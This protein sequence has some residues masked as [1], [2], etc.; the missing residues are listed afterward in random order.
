MSFTKSGVYTALKCVIDS[1]IPSNAGFYRPIT[2]TA[3]EGRSS[4]RAAPPRAPRAADWLQTRRHRA[5]RLAGAIPGR[6]PAAGD[7]GATMI[8]IG[9]TR[10]EDEAPFVYVDFMAGG[11][12]G[13]PGLDGVDGVSPL[14]ANLSRERTGRSR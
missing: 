5:R 9:G 7:G 11:W 14:A 10:D 8:A 13:R 3:P 1:D 12:G 4:I 2:V 6:V